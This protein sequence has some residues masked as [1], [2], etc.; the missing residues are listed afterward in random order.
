MSQNASAEVFARR[1][2]NTGD[3]LLLAYA[4]T[5]ARL[6]LARGR[7]QEA[8]MHAEHLAEKTEGAPASSLLLARVFLALGSPATADEL[9]TL[10]DDPA[11]LSDADKLALARVCL[12]LHHWSRLADVVA[13]VNEVPAELDAERNFL[14]AVALVQ[15][16]DRLAEALGILD[17]L[18]DRDAEDATAS[19]GGEPAP[20]PVPAPNVYEIATWRGV[21]LMRGQQTE[22]ARQVLN[23]AAELRADR[24]EAYYWRAMLEIRERQFDIAAV[25]L[26]NALA[27]SA[28]F[29]PAW[30]TLGLLALNRGELDAA[31]QNLAKAAEANQRQASTHFLI[32]IAYAKA[33]HREP[34]AEALQRAFQLDR[35]YVEEARRTDVLTRLFTPED[36]E[37]LAA[38]EA[39]EAPQP[40]EVTP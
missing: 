37:A 20:V 24:P 14:H 10:V 40:E 13:M 30:E 15:T 11:A 16:N 21:A 29:A 9:L 22:S 12:G 7:T 32:A 2:Y 8:L 28:R 6:F 23:D 25:F 26:Q 17:Y 38:A 31:L 1:A 4:E 33:S 27:T 34:A 19:G 39:A 5:S 35:K 3:P 36:F 18:A